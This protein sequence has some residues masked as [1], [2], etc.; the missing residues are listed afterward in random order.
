VRSAALFKRRSR[1]T[2]LSAEQGSRFTGSC[3]ASS[4][5]ANPH[6]APPPPR[7]RQERL[8]KVFLVDAPAIFSI[9][10][11]VSSM[12]AGGFLSEYTH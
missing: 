3:C 12:P 11:A 9:L 6:P 7:A 4:A 10:F 1:C 2:W 8:H 5:A